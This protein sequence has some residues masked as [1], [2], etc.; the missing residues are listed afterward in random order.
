MDLDNDKRGFTRFAIS[1]TVMIQS[2]PAGTKKT[3]KGELLDLSFK[4]VGFCTHESLMKGSSVIFLLLNKE[5]GLRLRG[6]AKIVSAQ[7]IRHKGEDLFKYGMQFSKLD[8]EILRDVILNLQ[9]DVKKGL[10]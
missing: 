3:L 5:L 1:G 2:G 6:E 9:K 8:S 4:G 10:G 7:K